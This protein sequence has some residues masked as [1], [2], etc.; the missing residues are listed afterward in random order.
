MNASRQQLNISEAVFEHGLRN[1]VVQESDD[2]LFLVQ[3]GTAF[4]YV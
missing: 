4:E 1:V 2:R 3:L